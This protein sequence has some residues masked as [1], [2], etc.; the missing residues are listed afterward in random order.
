MTDIAAAGL[1]LD[2]PK[3]SSYD[4]ETKATCVRRPAAPCVSF[5]GCAGVGPSHLLLHRC[6][7]CKAKS[8]HKSLPNFCASH[9]YQKKEKFGGT[10]VRCPPG[11]HFCD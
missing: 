3:C 2:A 11:S 10:K 6:V 1:S 7:V 8:T 5:L 4:S 9:G